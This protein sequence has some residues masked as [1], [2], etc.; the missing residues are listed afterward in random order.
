MKKMI[1]ITKE[2]SRLYLLES[3]DQ[4]KTKTISQQAT[5]KTW[6]S[7]QIWLPHRRLRYPLFNLNKSLFPCLF[8]K[9]SF[10]CDICQ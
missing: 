7:S 8:T 10:K 2:P 4:N 6:I 3:K 1:L 9:E 5:F